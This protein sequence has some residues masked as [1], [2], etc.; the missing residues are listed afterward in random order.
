MLK[1]KIKKEF[2]DYFSLEK[3]NRTL[4]EKYDWVDLHKMIE[5]VQIKK[6]K[7][8]EEAYVEEAKKAKLVDSNGNWIK[9]DGNATDEK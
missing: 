2:I 1:D 5:C 9:L 7:A 3:M 6:F 4:G 8:S